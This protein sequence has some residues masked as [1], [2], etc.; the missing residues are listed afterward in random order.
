MTTLTG[1]PTLVDSNFDNPHQNPLKLL[2][3]WLCEADRLSVSEPRALVLSTVNISKK[4]SS[5][6]D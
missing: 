6:G 1:N 2:E 5:R 3:L 4:P